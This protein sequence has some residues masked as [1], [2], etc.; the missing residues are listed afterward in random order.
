ML[1][2]I[3]ALV[4]GPA[5]M[6]VACSD[7]G[8]R[9]INVYAASSLVDI[10][11]EVEDRYEAEHSEIDIRMNLAGTN[12]LIRQI[13]SGADA[14]LLVAADA[15]LLS[16]LVDEPVGRPETLALNRLALVVPADNPAGIGSSDDLAD[17]TPLI[18]RCASGVPCGQA[19]DMFLRDQDLNLTR[20][21]DEANVRSVLTKVATGE[22][23]G[24]FVYHTDAVSTD[25]VMEIPLV[26]SPFVTITLARLDSDPSTE[27]LARYLTS[28]EVAD[29][30]AALGFTPPSSGD[31]RDP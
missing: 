13:N 24:G 30:F 31:D 3:L 16:D 6:V 5:G 21:T 28:N 4:P 23:D 26:D 22:V 1:L 25:D 18:A 14:A 2:F 9:P 17:G 27:A 19:T 15:G 10:M 11:T 7:G 12:A 20:T 8:R 29:L